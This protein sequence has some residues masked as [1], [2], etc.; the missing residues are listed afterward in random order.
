MA[1]AVDGTRILGTLR[2]EDGHGVVRI[3]D[4]LP[5]GVD[6]AW[7]AVTDPARLARWYGEVEGDLRAGGEYR[8]HVFASGWEGTS[9]ITQCEP[10]HRFVVVG[11]EEDGSDPQATTVT[12]TADGDATVLVIEQVGMPDE[13]IA[14]FG[15]G[16][17]VHVADLAR[18]LAGQG[19]CD[20]DAA[21]QALEPAY[22]ALA[23]DLK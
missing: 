8:A 22:D 1:D 13:L 6:D 4:R 17:Q 5:T 18:H 19:R 12:L 23:A 9:R 20:A 21:W 3:E 16:M 10:P 11:Q 2:M 14:A 15:A 7:S